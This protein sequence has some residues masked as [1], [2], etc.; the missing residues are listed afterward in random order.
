V[1]IVSKV[2]NVILNLS[3]TK[4]DRGKGESFFSDPLNSIILHFN[5]FVKTEETASG[6]FDSTGLLSLGFPAPANE[7]ARDKAILFAGNPISNLLIQP[8]ALPAPIPLPPALGSGM[9]T[10]AAVALVV[11]GRRIAGAALISP[12][13]VVRC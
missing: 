13:R 3:L 5:G 2:Y 12:L 7:E 11:G 1:N 10:L 6:S 8:T 9:I 4:A